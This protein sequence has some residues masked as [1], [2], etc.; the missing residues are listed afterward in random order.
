MWKS[1][2]RSGSQYYPCMVHNLVWSAHILCIG[3][4]SLRKQPSFI[5]GPSGISQIRKAA[6]TGYWKVCYIYVHFYVSFEK[7]RHSCSIIVLQVYRLV[8][9]LLFWKPRKILSIIITAKPF[10]E[11]TPSYHFFL[12]GGCT[13]LR[14]WRQQYLHVGPGI[15]N[16]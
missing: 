14:L 12:S 1:C 2:A 5:L 10:T 8:C 3:R 4:V 11:R 6:F 15:R 16:M 9:S 13:F 7:K